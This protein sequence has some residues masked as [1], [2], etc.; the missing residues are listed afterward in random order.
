MS[1]PVRAGPARLLLLACLAIT[2]TAVAAH[3]NPWKPPTVSKVT[4]EPECVRAPVSGAAVCVGRCLLHATRSIYAQTDQGR[5]G[6]GP[7]RGG[8]RP[9]PLPLT[10]GFPPAAA[11]QLRP[12]FSLYPP[13]R[14]L[15]DRRQL[16]AQAGGL[17]LAL[18]RRLCCIHRVSER[19]GLWCSGVGCVGSALGSDGCWKDDG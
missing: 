18:P 11:A 12:S 10:R 17:P 19:G 8:C 4:P 6:S 1:R 5:R 15:P 7:G 3:G 9:P 13:Q 2:A 14:H 16:G